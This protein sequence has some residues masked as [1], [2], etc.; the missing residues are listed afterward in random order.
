M[1]VKLDI[2]KA[3]DQ[4]EWGFL[5]AMMVKLGLEERWVTLAL[6]TVQTTSY[7]TLIN[8]EPHDF[9]SHTRGI[10]QGD[11]IFPYLFLICI[12]ELSSLLR[13]VEENR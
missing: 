3:Y 2:S 9:I 8:G 4:V 7:S 11:S 6:E 12:E 10:K 5:C 1:A 13:K